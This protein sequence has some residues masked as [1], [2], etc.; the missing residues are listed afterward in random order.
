M[1]NINLLKPRDYL[2]RLNTRKVYMLLSL[3]LCVWYDLTRNSE[4]CLKQ[5]QQIG[6]LQPRLKVFTPRYGLS[7]YIKQT[8]LIFKVLTGLWLYFCGLEGPYKLT[9][10]MQNDKVLQI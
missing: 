2:T 8:H 7:H 3:R 5:Y 6:F 10:L 9:H 1:R 4:F